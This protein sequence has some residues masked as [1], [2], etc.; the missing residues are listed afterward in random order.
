MMIVSDSA[1]SGAIWCSVQRAKNRNVDVSDPLLLEGAFVGA[2][3]SPFPGLAMPSI[4][5]PQRAARKSR[6]R[7]ARAAQKRISC[8]INDP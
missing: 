6:Y 4:A 2:P 5:G 1:L 3:R 7:R 8:I